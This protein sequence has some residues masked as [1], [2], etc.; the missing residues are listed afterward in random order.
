[1]NRVTRSRPPSA[2]ALL[3]IPFT[4][5]ASHHEGRRWSLM[6]EPEV[7]DVDHVEDRTLIAFAVSIVPVHEHPHEGAS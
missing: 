3:R 2:Y 7:V 1:V 4:R 6:S 5:P